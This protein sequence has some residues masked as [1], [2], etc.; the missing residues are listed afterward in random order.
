MRRLV[1][2]MLFAA[3][4]GTVCPQSQKKST[5]DTPPAK[6]QKPTN[7]IDKVLEFLSI[8]YTPGAQKGP[9]DEV[10]RGQVW[11]ADLDT[12]I[13]RPLAPGEDYRSPVFLASSGEILA[14]RGNDV[15]Q[16]SIA[17]GDVKKL[18]SVSNIVKIV[19]AGPNDSRKVL[20]LLRSDGSSHP[21]VGFMEVET[22][23]I[24]N[25]PY[26]PSLS[27]DLQMVESL[28]GWS[29]T[30]GDKRVFVKRQTKEALSGTVEW[31]D[32]FLVSSGQQS[33]DVSRCDGAN[34]GQ[35]S[36]SPNGRQVVYIKSG[37]E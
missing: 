12:K 19:G 3:L 10:V 6:Q 28:E 16:I 33:L 35:P 2:C 29:R 18:Y 23:L 24:T 17:R 36:L 9:G 5:T 7:F 32:A 30:Y 22:G 8:S 4:V 25:L 14:I 37:A 34:C 21:R 11:L 15:V 20:I 26:D 31:S 13:T 1:L 27:Q